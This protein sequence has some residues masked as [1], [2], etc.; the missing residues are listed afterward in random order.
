MVAV[1]QKVLSW[2]LQNV[3]K[4]GAL[5]IDVRANTGLHIPKAYPTYLNAAEYMTL[6]NEACLND[7]K[8]IQYDASTIYNTAVGANPYP[9]SWYE[10]LYWWIF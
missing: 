1:L 5:R 8:K 2:L 10:F 4:E 6:Y 3:V 9:L 7:G